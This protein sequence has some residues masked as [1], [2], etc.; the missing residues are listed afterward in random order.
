MAGEGK[1]NLVRLLLCLNA[2]ELR[3]SGLGST[4]RRLGGRS[5]RDGGAGGGGLGRLLCF[6][7]RPAEHRRVIDLERSNI[8]N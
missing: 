4:G 6:W 2:L 5:R 8:G 7:Q 1:S 3:R